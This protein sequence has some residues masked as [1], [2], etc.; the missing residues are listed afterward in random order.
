MEIPKSKGTETHNFV[1]V[2]FH[3]LYSLGISPS[4]RLLLVYDV[5]HGFT[6]FARLVDEFES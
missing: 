5:A 3:G 1:D 2:D 6:D 4:T